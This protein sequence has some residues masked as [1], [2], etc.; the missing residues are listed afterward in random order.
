MEGSRHE[1]DGAPV[2]Y[3]IRMA[4]KVHLVPNFSHGVLMGLDIIT[5]CGIDFLISRNLACMGEFM[6]QVK[7]ANRK[8]R[9]V[10]IWLKSDVTVHG[11]T[12]RCISITS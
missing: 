1:G 12:C 8:F 5:D 10:L 2:G 4:V 11:R 6:Y 3:L 7:S 9:L